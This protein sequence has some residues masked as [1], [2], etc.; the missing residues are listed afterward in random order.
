MLDGRSNLGAAAENADDVKTTIT[1]SV[2]RVP[3]AQPPPNLNEHSIRMTPGSSS[4][5]DYS[6]TPKVAAATIG[7]TAVGTSAIAMYHRIKDTTI[8]EIDSMIDKVKNFF[9]NDHSS[10]GNI[11]SS[12]TY[13]YALTTAQVL[14][15][16]QEYA[17]RHHR[18]LVPIWHNSSTIATTSAENEVDYVPEEQ[19]HHCQQGLHHH[20]LFSKEQPFSQSHNSSAT[21]TS[22]GANT[23]AYMGS[24][25]MQQ[26]PLGESKYIVDT[27][28]PPA[29]NQHTAYIPVSV[30]EPIQPSERPQQQPQQNVFKLADNKPVVESSVPVPAFDTTYMSTGTE[31]HATRPRAI[32]TSAATT[33]AAGTASGIAAYLGNK[34]ERPFKQSVP[35]AGAAMTTIRPLT[36]STP[37][38]MESVDQHMYQQK[39]P[40]HHQIGIPTGAVAATGAATVGTAVLANRSTHPPSAA[41]AATKSTMGDEPHHSMTDKIRDA[42]GLKKEPLTFTDPETLHPVTENR[43]MTIDSEASEP[44]LKDR[45]LDAIHHP[46]EHYGPADP[47]DLELTNPKTLRSLSERAAVPGTAGAAAAAAGTG[48]M[49]HHH[50]KIMQGA[51]PNTIAASESSLVF[52]DPYGLRPLSGVR[53]IPIGNDPHKP[54]L[55]DKI[56]DILHTSSEYGP[57]DPK[58][59]KLTDPMTLRPFGENLT[60]PSATAAVPVAAGAASAIGHHHKAAQGPATPNAT[61]TTDARAPRPAARTRT[62][63]VEVNTHRSKEASHNLPEYGSIDSKDMKLTSPKTP[64]TLGEKHTAPAVTGA[65]TT[66][67]VAGAGTAMDPHQQATQEIKPDATAAGSKPMFFT[68]PQALRPLVGVRIIPIV[69]ETHKPSLGDGIKEA[70]RHSFEYGPADPKDLT[71]TDPTNLR[72]LGEEATVPTVGMAMGKTQVHKVPTVATPDVAT[73]ARTATTSKPVAAG[74]VSASVPA[75]NTQL[76]SPTTTVSTTTAALDTSKPL[77][78]AG[79]ATGAATGAADGVMHTGRK[80]MPAIRT[81]SA[82]VTP[83]AHPATCTNS[84]PHPEKINL[85]TTMVPDSYNGPIPQVHPGEEIWWKTTTTTTY[86]DDGGYSDVNGDMAD[87]HQTGVA[88]NAYDHSGLNSVKHKRKGGFI[89]RLL[90][91]HSNSASKGK[92]RM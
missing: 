2:R 87:Y 38:R 52:T 18:H 12:N 25:K 23:A 33:A 31:R 42:M 9:H 58:D 43:T 54:T 81:T 45:I 35:A 68:D 86:Y 51:I 32:P 1:P 44:S 76:I 89:S 90:G 27:T 80:D 8:T 65:A 48:A 40:S 17:A 72:P 20:Q 62:I 34:R 22:V 92:Q 46:A 77:V 60:T 13:E 36:E 14:K 5:N 88:S 91:R 85:V 7:T 56:Q 55:K 11:Y 28:L 53:T 64:R 50:R 16:E 69:A 73:T 19:A 67:A 30:V 39:E 59:L 79:A 70:L 41:L 78:T 37:G 57:A 47:S 63:P 26:K 21:T 75:A 6:A 24:K 66:A 29:H 84:H 74:S 10:H 3:I 83:T 82:G 49:D 4:R 71:L 15:K 61:M